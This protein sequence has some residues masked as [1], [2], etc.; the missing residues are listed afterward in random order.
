MNKYSKPHIRKDP[1]GHFWYLWRDKYLC[2]AGIWPVG[3]QRTFQLIC[4]DAK[5]L[6]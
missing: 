3:R 2:D 1:G 4:A 6:K 5:A